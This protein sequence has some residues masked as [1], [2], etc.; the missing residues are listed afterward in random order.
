[1][2]KLARLLKRKPGLAVEAFQE[3]WFTGHGP[4]VAAAPGLIGY[5]QAHALVQGYRKGEL[6]FDA[7][8]HLTFASP[9][10]L[11]AFRRSPEAARARAEEAGLLDTARTVELPVEVHLIKDGAIPPGGVKNI[12]FVTRRPGMQLGAFRDYWRQ[13]HGPLAARIPPICRYEQHHTVLEAYEDGRRPAYDG[14]AVTWF[15]STADMKAGA[16]TPEYA[17]TRADE[18]AFLPDGHLPTIITREHVLLGG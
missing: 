4:L 17:E 15:H 13:V 3:R 6:I 8:E 5:V 16:Q 10:D 2:I 11:E 12:E 18:P 1:M 14:L 9:A 7:V